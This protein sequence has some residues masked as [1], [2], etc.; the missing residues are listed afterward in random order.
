MIGTQVVGNHGMAPI[1]DHKESTMRTLDKL[2]NWTTIL[3]LCTIGS[4][5]QADTVLIT[6]ANSGIGLE[7]ATQYAADGWHVVATHRRD[8]T[9]DTLAGLA[10]KYDNV[11][12]EKI[13]VTDMAT[14]SATARKLDGMPIDILINNAG[15]VGDITDPD[16]QF[17]NLN[18]DAY[19]RYMD[20]NFAG[21]LRVSEALYD[22][23]AASGQKKIVAISS[24]SGSIGTRHRHLEETV[25]GPPVRYWYD[26]SK[27]ALNM[28]FVAL[29]TDAI[30]DGVSVAVF[31]PGLVL[32][33]R[34]RKY[35][36]PEDFYTPVKESVSAFRE[37]FKEL[38][39]ATTGRFFDH[40]GDPMP[41]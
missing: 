28:A 36:L 15:V 39:P 21:P 13:D 1:H 38:S 22:N 40:R 4:L 30:D 10:N 26:S 2:L 33:E 23:V 16:Q 37:R 25:M 31:D 34:T 32:V 35:G 18:F 24:R 14:I 19:A 17:G 27:A 20:V 3:A 11:Q 6:G 41:W 29:A 5:A 9:P 8:T 12:I 7:F